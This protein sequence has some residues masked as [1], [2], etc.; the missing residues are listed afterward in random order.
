MKRPPAILFSLLFC[1]SC[2]ATDTAVRW[3]VES[4]REQVSLLLDAHASYVESDRVSEAAQHYYQ[5][6]V[7]ID[8]GWDL[9]LI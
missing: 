8:E 6:P 2:A 9:L 1:M 3:N 7:W 4:D 5:A